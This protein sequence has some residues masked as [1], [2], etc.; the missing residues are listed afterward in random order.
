LPL[1]TAA[2]VVFVAGIAMAIPAIIS[3]IGVLGSEARGTALALYAF[4]LFIG[5]SIGPLLAA[6]LIAIGFAALCLVLA[7]LM[8]AA[9]AVTLWSARRSAADKQL[10][11]LQA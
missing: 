11:A 10:T 8:L 4:F 5:A 6:R 9:A 3:R 7:V 1:L 2:S